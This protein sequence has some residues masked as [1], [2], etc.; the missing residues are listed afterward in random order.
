[1]R[2]RPF[3]FVMMLAIGAVIS[4]FNHG[5][6]RN[7]DHRSPRRSAEESVRSRRGETLRGRVVRIADGDT[8]TVLDDRNTQ[9]KIRLFGIDA[10]E[11]HQEF[12]S[13]AKQSLSELCF[14]QDVE[15]EVVDTD[16]YGRTV[17]RIFAGETDV[18]MEQV[19]RGMAWDYDSYDK[20]HE[21][22]AAE[23]DAR[24][25]QRGLWADRD[26]TPPWEFRREAREEPATRRR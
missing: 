16:R 6:T 12:G 3:A 21:F 23:R 9:H 8:L 7:G 25:H 11:T 13:R 18:N 5:S 2:N 15:V 10:P 22:A 24:D 19:R 14:D 20:R 1:M 26:P 17:G 4:Y